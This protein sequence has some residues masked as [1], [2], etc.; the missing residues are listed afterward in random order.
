MEIETLDNN[1]EKQNVLMFSP[2]NSKNVEYKKRGNLVFLKWLVRYDNEDNELK[3]CLSFMLDKNIIQR[4]ELNWLYENTR[5]CSLSFE[6][7]LQQLAQK[8]KV[9]EPYELAME[10]LGFHVSPTP[11]GAASLM[12]TAYRRVEE[13]SWIEISLDNKQQALLHACFPIAIPRTQKELEELLR[14]DIAD[15]EKGYMHAID[16]SMKYFMF[17]ICMILG[18]LSE[19]HRQNVLHI[20]GNLLSS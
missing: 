10:S 19:N 14:D 15:A 11:N 2:Q 5:A 3:K 6:K 18:M 7:I 20:L 13:I 4:D 12:F 17:E 8:K 1:G 9:I 16:D